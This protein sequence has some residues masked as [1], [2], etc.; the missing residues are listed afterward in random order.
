[1]P[2][3]A[4]HARGAVRPW[5][6]V[7]SGGTGADREALWAARNLKLYPVAVQAAL[8]EEAS[9]AE[10]TRLLVPVPGRGAVPLL[11]LDTWALMNME[12]DEIL[13]IPSRLTAEHGVAPAVLT[14]AMSR[15]APQS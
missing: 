11:S 10:A 3:K 4:A 7:T 13:A 12:V 8:R 15:H 2:D 1:M 6:H 9:L 14:D 5:G